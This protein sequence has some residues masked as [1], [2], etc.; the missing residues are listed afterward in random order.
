MAVP[1]VGF[2]PPDKFVGCLLLILGVC[3]MAALIPD[4][5]D[6]FAQLT[7]GVWIWEWSSSP[8][9]RVVLAIQGLLIALGALI[10]LLTGEWGR[11]LLTSVAIVSALIFITPLGGVT[12]FLGLWLGVRVVVVERMNARIGKAFEHLLEARSRKDE[13][14]SQADSRSPNR[15][16]DGGR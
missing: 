16:P 12:F 14:P 15:P 4:I 1:P 5:A 13:P 11:H 9:G 2:S 6:R 10:A 8:T 7:R 3:G